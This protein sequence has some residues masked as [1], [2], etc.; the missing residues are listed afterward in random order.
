MKKK[1]GAE[2][3]IADAIEINLTT[4]TII[5]VLSLM[6]IYNKNA[7]AFINIINIFIQG[8]GI[9]FCK[10]QLKKSLAKKRD[11]LW[12]VDVVAML[13]TNVIFWSHSMLWLLLGYR[14]L[15]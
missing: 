5:L 15:A 2:I 9:S 11:I 6:G 1:K 10:Y 8:T 12:T 3:F 7:H 14:L 4:I 13:I